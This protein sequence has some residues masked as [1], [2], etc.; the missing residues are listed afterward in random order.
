MTREWDTPVRGPW[1][2]LIKEALAG[3]DR[4]EALYRATGLGGHAR[5]AALL[6][7]YV[8]ELK[9]WIYAEEAQRLEALRANVKRS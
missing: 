6:R 3:I 8:T 5:S 1:N 7:N 9:D 4:H 2:S